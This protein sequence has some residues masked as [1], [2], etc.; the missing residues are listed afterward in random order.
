MPQ[1][2]APVSARGQLGLGQAAL[3]QMGMG[4]PGMGQALP[5]AP[6]S[7]SLF[8]KLLKRSP[9]PE[10]SDAVTAE[11]AGSGSLL[12]KKF[13]LGAVA[14]FVAAF[15]LMMALDM[16]AA[17]PA[18]QAQSLTRPAVQTAQ[19]SAPVRAEGGDTFLDNAIASDAP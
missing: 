4:Q 11:P 15:A 16:F 1:L 13:G 12:G 14:G 18:Q 3:G 7:K 17:E 9:K 10:S 6:P 5:E 19:N 2:Q 8:A